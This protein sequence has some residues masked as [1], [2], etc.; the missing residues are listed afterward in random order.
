MS[1]LY[2]VD[3]LGQSEVARFAKVSQ[4][5][6]SRLLALARERGIVRISVAEY[7]PRQHRLELALRARLGL[8]AVIVIKT[9]EGMAAADLRRAVGHFAAPAVASMLKARDIVALAGGRTIREVVQQLPAS[10]RKNLSVIQ[11]MGSVDAR[12]SEFDAQEVGRIM[13]Q[14]LGGTFWEL[15]APAFISE[16]RTRDALLALPQVRGVQERLGR[17]R[18]ALVGVGT[19]ENSIFVDRAAWSAGAVTELRR[20][21]AMGEICG[22]FFDETGRECDTAWRDRVVGIQLEQLK[23]IP[24]VIGIVSGSDRSHALLA[25][26]KGRLINS[27]VIDEAGANAV[28]VAAHQGKTKSINSKKLSS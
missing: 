23:K 13:V 27:L 19:L 6:V 14:R 21:G 18:V 3:G 16:R 15:N 11:A 4:A 20:H 10:P 24:R 9:Q 25:A 17:A 5:K 22:R 2:H 8:D 1:R 7:E 26:I 28:L 12:A